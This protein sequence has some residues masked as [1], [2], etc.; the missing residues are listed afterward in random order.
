MKISE[1]IAEF[2]SAY[3]DHEIPKEAL[4]RAKDGIIDY[5]G[6]TL[7][8][9]EEES[10][11]LA[12]EVIKSLGGA[13]QA[14]VWSTGCK[15]SVTSA[16][17]VNGTAAHALDFDDTNLVMVAHPS[18]QLLPGLCALGEYQHCSGSDILTAYIIGFELG[19]VFGS[20]LNPNHI[21]Q[22]WF[23]VGTL[24]LVM[25]TAASARLLRL[26][27]R[28]TQMA[29]GLSMNLASGLRCNS[30]TMAKPLLAGH[31]ASNSVLVTLLARNGITAN[32][33]TLEDRFGYFENFS[34]GNHVDL[35]HAINSLGIRWN[36]VESGISFKLYPCCAGAHI[37]IDCALEIAQRHSLL[38]EEIESVEISIPSA[39]KIVLLHPSPKT[40]AEA[41]FSLEYCVSRAILDRKLGL[42]QFL[43]QKIN[44]S[45]VR[46][47][48]GKINIKYYDL[49]PIKGKTSQNRFPVKMRV[50]LKGGA[51][52]SACAEY[53]K[54]TPENPA[55]STFLEEKLYQCCSEK[56]PVSRV[57]DIL[58]RLRTFEQ[59]K[60][61]GELISM[62]N[63]K[64]DLAP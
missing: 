19:V 12:R 6:V 42:E 58:S 39:V 60:D 51:A 47:L 10:V 50:C 49:S 9:G 18:I 57:R 5:A 36:I 17:L 32:P 52:F 56:L 1:R 7:A 30:G 48:M 55:S 21:T 43:P 33:D 64:T 11:K 27:P 22:G 24:G 59:I 23:P 38:P 8:G 20:A 25:Q 46:T 26:T 34:R 54:G 2:I 31:A 16:A 62:F 13:P 35:E 4:L 14:T 40:V 53:A 44:D 61:I 15:T 41:R 63:T 37:P 28:Q 45:S 3:S 29:M